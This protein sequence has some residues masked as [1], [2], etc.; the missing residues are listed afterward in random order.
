MT[1]DMAITYTRKDFW[2][3]TFVVSQAEV[4]GNTFFNQNHALEKPG[5]IRGISANVVNNPNEL[6]L[7]D[8]RIHAMTSMDPATY[9]TDTKLNDYAVG[10]RTMA[11]SDTAETA[12]VGIMV[13]VKLGK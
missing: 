7:Y 6:L 10:I 11:I 9:I 2:E 1:H 3:E 8:I 13:T 5:H 4:N 12:Q